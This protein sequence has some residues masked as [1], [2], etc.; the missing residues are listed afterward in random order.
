MKTI[1]RHF[2]SSQ[3]KAY[4]QIFEENEFTLLKNGQ[5]FRKPSVQVQPD[6]P[7]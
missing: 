4:K 5:T 3:Q 6:S 7:L 1:S 2:S